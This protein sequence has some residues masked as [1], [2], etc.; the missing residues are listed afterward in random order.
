M[1]LTQIEEK[2]KMKKLPTM[3]KLAS[4]SAPKFVFAICLLGLIAL[5]ILGARA[6]AQIGSTETSS[7]QPTPTTKGGVVI[8]S[9]QQ[10]PDPGPGPGGTPPPPPT[11]APT[12]IPTPTWNQ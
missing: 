8:S 4:P 5:T 11:P 12:P 6:G 1:P 7:A 2:M 10:E 9:V 3:K